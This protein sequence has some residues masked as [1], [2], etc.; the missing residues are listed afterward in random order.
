MAT[1]WLEF[2]EIEQKKQNGGY[3]R[4]TK[5][6]H[7]LS[8]FSRETLA[9]I[10]WHSSWRKYCFFPAENTIFDTSCLAEIVKFICDLM[11]ERQKAGELIPN[12]TFSA[13]AS[14]IQPPINI[15]AMKAF[16]DLTG[17]PETDY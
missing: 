5:E 3:K 9:V 12:Q 1:R 13:G 6:F 14:K 4:K 8:K 17:V 16:T 11:V 7:V 2:K 10:K 15:S